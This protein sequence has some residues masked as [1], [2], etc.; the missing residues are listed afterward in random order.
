MPEGATNASKLIAIV[1]DLE[2]GAPADAIG[3]L[4][5]LIGVL[6]HLERVAVNRP[7]SL[8]P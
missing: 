2:S 7:H 6:A 4:K 1:E 3:T 8:L 5:V